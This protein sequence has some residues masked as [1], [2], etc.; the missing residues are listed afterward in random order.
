MWQAV[1]A[2]QLLVRC[3]GYN[4]V[5]TENKAY[6]YK[7]LEIAQRLGLLENTT[8]NISSDEP[9][10]YGNMFILLLNSMRSNINDSTQ[11]LWDYS[12]NLSSYNKTTGKIISINDSEFVVSNDTENIN[13]IWEYEE[14]IS[15]YLMF[16]E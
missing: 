15:S 12:L 13:L 11:K 5:K 4:N 10:I 1:V 9:M 7:Y 6:P 3:L 16:T 2:R 14:D 8:I